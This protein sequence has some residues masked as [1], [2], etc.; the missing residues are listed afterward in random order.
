MQITI[1]R[2]ALQRET[3]YWYFSLKDPTGLMAVISST[4]FAFSSGGKRLGIYPLF[5]MLQ[6][7]S[8]MLSRRIWVSEKRK[9]VCFC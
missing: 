6:T 2:L 5:K 7:S 1:W 8:T 4:I 3:K 9:I